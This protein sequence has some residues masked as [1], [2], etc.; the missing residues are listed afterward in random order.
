MSRV[1]DLSPAD[2]AALGVIAECVRATHQAVDDL[3]RRLA[4][5]RG[6]ELTPPRPETTRSQTPRPKKRSYRLANVTRGE[7]GALAADL[8]YA[9]GR[10][11]RFRAARNQNGDLEGE[12]DDVTDAEPMPE[13]DAGEAPSDAFEGVFGSLEGL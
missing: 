5:E 13:T 2:I 9:D 7:D 4:R 11:R 6:I 10:V 12:L 8:Q 3:T 1:P